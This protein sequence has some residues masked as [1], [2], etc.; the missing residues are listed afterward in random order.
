ML[1]DF[2]LA[3]TG[4]L[5]AFA[6]GEIAA[7]ERGAMDAAYRMAG[8]GKRALRGDV[9]RGGLGRR[10]ANSWR[11]DVYPK[12]DISMNPA[13]RFKSSAPLLKNAFEQGAEIRSQ[14]GNFLAVPTPEFLQGLS[15]LA[16]SRSRKN[17][18]TLAEKIYGRLRFVPVKGKRLGLLV[19][20][21]AQKS[22]GQRGGFRAASA[23]TLRKGRAES[24]VLFVLVP[25]ARLRKRLNFTKIGD[26][27][28]RDWPRFMSTGI[29]RSLDEGRVDG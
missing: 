12:R 29:T 3:L 6:D 9:I 26:G 19:T 11:D 23:A 21:A 24:I 10:L 22:R 15:N 8:R 18:I 5:A 7:I 28:A 17:L 25:R 20:D 14:N 4:D 13:V 16:R 27:L 2:Q 1:T